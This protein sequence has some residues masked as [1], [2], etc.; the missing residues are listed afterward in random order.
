MGSVKTIV[1][2]GGGYA[3]INLIEA[4]KKEFHRELKRNIRVILIDKNSFH[5]KKVK[6]FKA[7]VH[8]N[9]ADLSVPLKDYCGIDIEFI[10]GELAKIDPKKQTIHITVQDGTFNEI[11]YDQLV[12]AMGSVMREADSERGGLSLTSLERAKTIREQLLRKLE[13]P[14]T[15]LRLAI[16]GSGIT[17]IETAAEVGTWLKEEAEKAGNK[18]KGIEIY[19]INDKQRLLNDVPVKISERIEGRLKKLGITVLHLKK[20]ERFTD[21]TLYFSDL[22]HL[23]ADLCIWT[24]GLKPHPDLWK[25]GLSLTEEGKIKVDAWYRASENNIYAIG[26]CVHVVDPTSGAAAGMSCKEAISQA[27]RLSKIMKAHIEESTAAPHQTYPKLLCIG[28]GPSVG[29]VWAQKWGID[30]VLSGKMAG[31]IREYTWDLAS[32]NH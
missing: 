9:V 12:L 6:L 17:G 20:A 21:H 11:Y 4:L 31:E 1:V 27:Q 30:F 5:F 29:M 2:V 23:D 8:E 3:G 25:L 19:L 24:V 32:I 13:S 26:D 22:S 16:A 10:Q 14:E 7:I 18:Q 15:R 28:L